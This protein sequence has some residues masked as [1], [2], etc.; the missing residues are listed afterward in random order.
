MRLGPGPR[1]PLAWE[2]GE[3]L[4]MIMDLGPDFPYEMH[5]AWVL[6]YSVTWPSQHAPHPDRSLYGPWLPWKNPD[7]VARKVQREL[8]EHPEHRALCRASLDECR[9]YLEREMAL[10]ALRGQP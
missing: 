1:I 7:V 2:L 6:S 4:V 8:A 3:L 10:R 5:N 9:E